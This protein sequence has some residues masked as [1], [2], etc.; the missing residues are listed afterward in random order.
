MDLNEEARPFMGA[1]ALRGLGLLL[2]AVLTMWPVTAYASA[3][4]VIPVGRAVGIKLFST[5]VAEWL[6]CGLIFLI[7]CIADEGNFVGY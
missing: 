3:P 6:L 7:H 5:S 4:M 1:A 2:A